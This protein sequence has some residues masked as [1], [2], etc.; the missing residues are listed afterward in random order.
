VKLTDVAPTGIIE[1]LLAVNIG[2]VYPGFKQ[3]GILYIAW[4][5]TAITKDF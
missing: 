3:S 5:P 2:F 4:Y 1:D